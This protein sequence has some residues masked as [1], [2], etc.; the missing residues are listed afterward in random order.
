MYLF[1]TDTLSALIRGRHPKALLV[2]LNAVPIE[3]RFTSSINI[4]EMAYGAFRAPHRT[5]ELLDSIDRTI[6]PDFAVL[7]FDTNAALRY[8]K[9][10]RFLERRG[11]PIGDADTRIAAIALSR[12]LTVV[13][14][15]TRHFRRVPGL[16]VEN[17]LRPDVS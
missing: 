15:N 7:P 6:L 5:Q 16:A 3:D 17:W 1:D 11:T 12:N 9:L 10:R 13:T 4:G 2:K 14:G 8:G